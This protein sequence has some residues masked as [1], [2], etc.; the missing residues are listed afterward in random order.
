M[1]MIDIKLIRELTWGL[2]ILIVED[3]DD[4]RTSL[5]NTFK[6]LFSEVD[7]AEDGKMAFSMCDKKNYHIVM[8]DINMPNMNGIQLVKLLRLKNSGQK[9]IMCTAH[10]DS[11]YLLDLI[12]LGV[13]GFLVKPFLQK[14]LREVLYQVALSIYNTHAT[15]EYIVS[16]ENE[17]IADQKKE[18]KIPYIAPVEMVIPKPILIEPLAE[19]ILPTAHYEVKS[20]AMKGSEHYDNISNDDIDEMKDLLFEMESFVFL[21]MQQQVIDIEYIDDFAKCLVRYGNL[22]LYY[23]LFKDVGS[24]VQTLGQTIRENVDHLNTKKEYIGLLLE[25][26]ITT[27]HAIWTNAFVEYST[28]PEFYNN[29]IIADIQTLLSEFSNEIVSNDDCD[30]EFF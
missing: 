4:L 23:P 16:L 19:V 12:K 6:L 22:L 1:T 8:T 24:Y 18:S 28:T 14:Q 5:F 25:N 13:D 30:M 20:D 29:S 26:F 27:L 21:G 2:K 7:V 10:S 15:N 17:L 11:H 3:E 9:I